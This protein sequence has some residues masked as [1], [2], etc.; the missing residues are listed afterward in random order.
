MNKERCDLI[1]YLRSK[2]KYIYKIVEDFCLYSQ[3]SP[4][5][6]KKTKKSL[7]LSFINPSKATCDKLK[8]LVKKDDVD[9]VVK[10]LR[11]HLLLGIPESRT[12]KSKS[13]VEYEV[14]TSSKKEIDLIKKGSKPLHLVLD[15]QFDKS[16]IRVYNIKSGDVTVSDGNE[17]TIDDEKKGGSDVPRKSIPHRVRDARRL[18]EEFCHERSMQSDRDPYME[19]IGGFLGTMQSLEKIE[20]HTAYGNIFEIVK[21][22]ID[23]CPFVS[24]HLIFEPY[25]GHRSNAHFDYIIDDSIYRRVS[26]SMVVHNPK[27]IYLQYLNEKS[28]SPDGDLEN[29]ITSIRT[30][31]CSDTRHNSITDCIQKYYNEIDSRGTVDGK[32]LGLSSPALQLFKSNPHMKMWQDLFRLN[33]GEAFMRCTMT[34][35]QIAEFRYLNAMIINNQPGTD[36]KKELIFNYPYSTGLMRPVMPPST[37]ELHFITKRF[38]ASSDLFYIPMSIKENDSVGSLRYDGPQTEFVNDRVNRY[39]CLNKAKEIEFSDASKNF[40]LKCKILAQMTGQ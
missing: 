9:E 28:Q 18:Y 36:Y 32:S 4:A 16:L 20:A 11:S 10:C 15:N 5:I 33:I 40:E 30:N 37:S 14:E 29:T 13:G 38:I 2:N 21:S 34:K 39:K 27:K 25:K 3:F 17:T 26:D 12:I 7:G 35:F 19:F 24:Y 8:Q 31:I 22:I 23:P 6:G 1:N